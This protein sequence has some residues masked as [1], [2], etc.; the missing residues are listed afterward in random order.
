MS[1][2]TLAMKGIKIGHVIKKICYLMNINIKPKFNKIGVD[3]NQ[4]N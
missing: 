2:T 1:V 3:K 4:K